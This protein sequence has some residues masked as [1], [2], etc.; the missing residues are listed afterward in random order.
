MKKW[1]AAILLITILIFSVLIMYTTVKENNRSVVTISHNFDYKIDI[2]VATIGELA[3]LPGIS[4][5]KAKNIVQ[6]REKH[7]FEEIS[8]IKKVKGIGESLYK[9]IES[10]ITV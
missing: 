10:L 6:Y 7:P 4:T 2:N 9:E 1:Y 5:E 8:D 3:Y